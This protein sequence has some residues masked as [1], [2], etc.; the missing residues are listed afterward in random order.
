MIW[1]EGQ[2]HFAVECL[3]VLDPQDPFPD[4]CLLSV[5]RYELLEWAGRAATEFAQR[6]SSAA[7]FGQAV[8][9]AE[10]RTQGLPAGS[11]IQGHRRGSGPHGFTHLLGGQALHPGIHER[12]DRSLRLRQRRPIGHRDGQCLHGRKISERRGPIG[13]AL[14]PGAERHLQ[15]HYGRSGIDP[16][17]LGHGRGCGRLRQ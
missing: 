1:P 8:L 10:H 11:G 13:D 5:P 7:P 14:A 2:K 6:P 3:Y 16:A 12:R 9:A 15:G 4:I 17:R